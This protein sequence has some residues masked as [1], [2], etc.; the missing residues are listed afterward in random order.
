[1]KH[2]YPPHIAPD[3]SMDEK[4]ALLKK[5]AT[6]KRFLKSVVRL[7]AA[8]LDV[9]MP[10]CRERV[11]VASSDGRV[12]FYPLLEERVHGEFVP[13]DVP[14]RGSLVDPHRRDYLTMVEK[15]RSIASESA[16]I[17]AAYAEV[18]ASQ[19]EA[20]EAEVGETHWG[21]VAVVLP[22]TVPGWPTALHEATAGHV[23]SE[24]VRA[25]LQRAT[26][27]GI[28]EDA[29]FLGPVEQFAG[30]ERPFVLV[31]GFHHPYHRLSRA[32]AARGRV[33]A[34]IYQAVT[35]C[36]FR[37]SVLEVGVSQFAEHFE[38]RSRGDDDE[39]PL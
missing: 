31:V 28:D 9:A 22:S 19:L 30:L 34:A 20:L 27:S 13:V 16:A 21:L 29:L 1:M 11:S 14:Y 33:D 23:R 35:R 26:P 39:V 4:R 7:P 6:R 25:A 24:S 17:E 15:Y 5:V 32:R 12:D 37:L 10:F 3:A 36:T 2:S 8:A 18:L 38:L